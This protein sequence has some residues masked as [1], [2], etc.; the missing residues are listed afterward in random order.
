MHPFPVEVSTMHPELG[1]TRNCA[2]A[3]HVPQRL[4]FGRM[5]AEQE[6]YEF[7]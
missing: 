1:K 4:K 7:L 5:S 2:Q 6:E 3:D